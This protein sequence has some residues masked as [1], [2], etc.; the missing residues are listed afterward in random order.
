MFITKSYFEILLRHFS[1]L[2]S[3]NEQKNAFLIPFQLTCCPMKLWRMWLPRQLHIRTCI[4]LCVLVHMNFYIFMWYAPNLQLT[5]CGFHHMESHQRLYALGPPQ[6]VSCL[7]W[8]M[9]TE[10]VCVRSRS[11]V[12]LMHVSYS[13]PQRESSSNIQRFL[14]KYPVT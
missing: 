4:C 7:R 13:L 11:N 12:F 3:D 10:S 5:T 9:S 2:V 1:A 14:S 8:P 6:A